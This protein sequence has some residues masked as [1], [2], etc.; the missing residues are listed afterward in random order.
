MYRQKFRKPAMVLASVVAIVYLIYRIGFTLNLITPYAVSSSLLLLVG[1]VYGIA[2]M[3]LYFLQIWHVTEP[4][5]QPVLP[6][7]T[8]DVFIATYNEDARLLR[9]TIQAC[10]RLDYPHRTYVLDDG[11]R[12]EIQ[13]L[14]EELGALYVTRPDN[15][16]AKAGN[17]NNALKH[18]DGEFVIVLDADH[19][20]EQHFITRVIGY[21]ADKKLAFVQTPH[22]FYN[23]DSFQASYDADKKRYWEEGDVFSRLVQQ[24]RNRFHCA[25]FAGSAAM[26]RRKALEEIGGFAVETI[27]EDLHTGIRVNGKGWKS[28]AI[29]ER[30]IAGQAAPDVT[31][32]HT[33]RLRWTKGNL[34]IMTYDNPLTMP[35]LTLAQRLCH[36]AACSIWLGGAFRLALYFTPVLFLFTGVAPVAEYTWTLV[37]MVALY[38]SATWSAL[39]LASNGHFSFWNTELFEMMA[40]WTKTR[41][42]VQALIWR[43]RGP[44]VVTSKRGRQ[45]KR[46][47][48]LLRPHLVLALVTILALCWGWGGFLLGLSDNWSKLILATSWGGFY[49]ALAF[50]I[51]RRGLAPDDARYDY[52][53]PVNLGLTYI[54]EGDEPAKRAPRLGLT[55]DVSAS[56]LGILSYEPLEPGTVLAIELQGGGDTL[57]CRGRVA[58]TKELLRSEGMPVQG[59][60]NGV[61][62]EDLTGTQLDVLQ[63]LCSHYAVSRQYHDIAFGDLGTARR[64]ASNGPL[65]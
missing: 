50:V 26:F 65:P 60:R 54:V 11:R 25:C 10:L 38:L 62:L 13:A 28:L 53:H 18:S 47:W 8:V 41:G 43:G 27:T 61:A 4:P 39:A 40:F 24:G 48:P 31:T 20:P 33:Q 32:F 23:L 17:L 15:Q 14:A 6:N 30:L 55:V 59:F 22:A 45:S 12:P 44:F 57:R 1:E 56:G 35:G 7:R 51:I 21:F 52:R 64:G 5:C 3:L 58:W 2:M 42:A 16:H 9:A 46:I 63:H 36:F 34:S 19:V 37:I 29:S 49:A